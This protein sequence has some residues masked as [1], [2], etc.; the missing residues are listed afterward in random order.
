MPTLLKEIAYKKIRN[1][2]NNDE[3]QH[4]KV[5]SINA[6]ASTLDMSRT[7]VRDA[8]QKLSE[9]NAV[10]ILTSKGFCLHEMTPEE[11]HFNMHYSNAIEGYCVYMLARKYKIDPDNP[12]VPQLKQLVEKMSHLLSDDSDFNEYYT[13]DREFHSVLFDSIED[14]MFSKLKEQRVGLINHPE[15]QREKN[16]LTRQSVYECHKKIIDA[17]CDGNEHT[18]YDAMT[19]HALIMPN[20]LEKDL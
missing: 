18:A 2:I 20:A 19:E 6:I 3:L 4:G 8:V 5:Y 15:L 16:K 11:L 17:I 14:P 7:P 13:L 9:E 10:D 1:M 12:Y